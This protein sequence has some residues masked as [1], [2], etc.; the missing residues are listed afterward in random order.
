MIQGQ[1]HIQ[2]SSMQR[3]KDGNDVKE[4]ICN[5]Y[6][7]NDCPIDNAKDLHFQLGRVIVQIEDAQ[8]AQLEA[9]KAQAEAAKT[10]EQPDISPD[11]KSEIEAVN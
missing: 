7:D 8:K 10:K 9:A 2:L 11:S 5:I 4:R 3:D 1:A 6:M